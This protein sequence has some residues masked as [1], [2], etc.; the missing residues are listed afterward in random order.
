MLS[1]WYIYTA[2]KYGPN[3]ALKGRSLRSLDSPK[4]RML[5]ILRAV[6]V[7]PLALR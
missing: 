6:C 1:L 5:R 2:Y 4:R 3:K 7:C